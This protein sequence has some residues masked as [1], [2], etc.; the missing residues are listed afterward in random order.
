MLLG[1]SIVY[2]NN[3]FLTLIIFFQIR[4]LKIYYL[5]TYHNVYKI[6]LFF[7]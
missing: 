6:E 3:I 2:Y 4:E 1:L 5:S 7:K